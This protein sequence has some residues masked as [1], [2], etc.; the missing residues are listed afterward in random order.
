[1]NSNF[2]SGSAGR[3]ETGAGINDSTQNISTVYICGCKIKNYKT[4]IQKSI[5]FL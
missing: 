1:M 5:L 2:G 4:F 3:I